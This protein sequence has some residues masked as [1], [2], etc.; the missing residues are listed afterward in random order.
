[1]PGITAAALAPDPATPSNRP[2]CSFLR[3]PSSSHLWR[4]S[5]RPPPETLQTAGYGGENIKIWYWCNADG[6]TNSDAPAELLLRGLGH[7]LR[8]PRRVP[9]DV[10]RRFLDALE[11]LEFPL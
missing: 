4:S 2:S 7:H 10:H 9:D 1:M 3:R 11:L 6:R 5:A 8:G